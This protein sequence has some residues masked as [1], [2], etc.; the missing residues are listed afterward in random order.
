MSVIKVKFYLKMGRMHWETKSILVKQNKKN[1]SKYLRERER[2]RHMHNRATAQ[3]NKMR[4]Y[5]LYA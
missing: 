5:G 1:T 3:D 2:E 4:A